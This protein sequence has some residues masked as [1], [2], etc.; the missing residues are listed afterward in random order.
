MPNGLTKALNLA[1]CKRPP[2]CS[3]KQEPRARMPL[4]CDM[5]AG[6]MSG[7]KAV[8]NMALCEK[9][10]AQTIDEQLFTLFLSE[11]ASGF[12]PLYKVLQTF[13]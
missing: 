10:I 4:W 1:A 6:S 2:M 5:P 7:V 9:K 3:A 11:V 8:L 12:E 13:A